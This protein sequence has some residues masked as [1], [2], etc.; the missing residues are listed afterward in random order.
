[1]LACVLEVVESRC[2]KLKLN[3]WHVVRYYPRKLH[4]IVGLVGLGYKNRYCP[5]K[6]VKFCFWKDHKHPIKSGS[7]MPAFNKQADVDVPDKYCM[8]SSDHSHEYVA[9]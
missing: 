7:P 8:T 1:M 4:S 5:S 9:F 3:A 6:F 2:E